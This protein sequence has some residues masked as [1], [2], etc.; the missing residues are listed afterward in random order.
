[1]ILIGKREREREGEGLNKKGGR[2]GG[3]QGGSEKRRGGSHVSL[4]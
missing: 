1:L 3:K 2:E 4:S